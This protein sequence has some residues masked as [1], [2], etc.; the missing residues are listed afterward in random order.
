M[1]RRYEI[2]DINKQLIWNLRDIG[3]T[4]RQMAEGRGSQ[5]RVLGILNETGTITQSELTQ[6][7]GIQPGS[8]SEVLGKL[9]AAG[10]ILRTPSETDHRTMDIQLTEQGLFEAEE[11]RQKMT[12][13]YQRM[14]SCITDEEKET[15]LELLEKVNSSWDQEYRNKVEQKIHRMWYRRK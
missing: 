3:H 8:A 11:G 4:I 12:E 13:R 7:L 5:R 10:L 14:F 6:R 1:D 2:S 15:L 9:E